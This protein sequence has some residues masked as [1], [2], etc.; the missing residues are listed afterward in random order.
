MSPD[1]VPETTRVFCEP[2]D[3]GHRT[4]SSSGSPF[5][6]P[7]L[8]VAVESVRMRAAPSHTTVTL[9]PG[10]MTKGT[11]VVA[12]LTLVPVDVRVPRSLFSPALACP[13]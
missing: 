8:A 7:V 12:L 3:V 10:E 4:P 9:L 5:V 13:P 11:A 6:A 2:T 1:V